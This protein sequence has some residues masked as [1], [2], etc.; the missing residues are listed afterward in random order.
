MRRRSARAAA[1]ALGALAAAPA[2]AEPT[3]EGPT[4]EGPT[5]EGRTVT[6]GV[7]VTDEDAGAIFEGA[8][9]S[10][11]VGEGVEF[12][13]D[14]EGEQN[15]VDVVPA[16]VDVGPRRLEIRPQGEGVF[17]RA[18]FNGYVLAFEAECLLFEG[19][20]LDPRATTLPLAEGAVAVQG[21]AL[22][23]DVSGLRHDE[24]SVIAVDLAMAECV[25]S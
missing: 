16:A 14:E 6:F 7:R 19:A 5:L 21:N 9:H 10:A 23:I 12:A 2:A 13:L 8:R 4:L 11:V 22:T 17:A 24:D 25:L 15:G 1:L 18:A 20:A 3:L